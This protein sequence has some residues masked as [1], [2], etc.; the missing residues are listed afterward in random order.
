MSD[1]NIPT[2]NK[3]DLD[4]VR[5]LIENEMILKDGEQTLNL[6]EIFQEGNNKGIKNIN[7]SL[8]FNKEYMSDFSH[9]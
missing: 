6:T 4:N 3:K 1:R 8:Y 7:S 9:S 2:V 5:Q